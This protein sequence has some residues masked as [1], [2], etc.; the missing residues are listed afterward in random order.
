[1]TT[2]P[3]ILLAALL[4]LSRRPRLTLHAIIDPISGLLIPFNEGEELRMDEL[5]RA[6]HKILQQGQARTLFHP[7]SLFFSTSFIL[8]TEDELRRLDKIDFAMDKLFEAVIIRSNREEIWYRFSNSTDIENYKN[9]PEYLRQVRRRLNKALVTLN[10][11]PAYLI[12]TA[13]AVVTE[14]S[15]HLKRLRKIP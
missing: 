11:V 7:I 4:G 3:S 13:R 8:L 15:A 10:G 5:E 1:M 12:P 9:V 6:K 14:I 2:S